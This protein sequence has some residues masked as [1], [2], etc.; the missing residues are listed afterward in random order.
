MT[1]DIGDSPKTYFTS[2]VAKMIGVAPTTVR[3]YSQS[4][5]SKGYS[6]LKGKGTGNRQ[7]RLFTDKDITVMRYLKEIRKDTNITVERATSIVIERF[8]KG[9]IQSTLS[10]H[11]AKTD[12][13]GQHDER[14]NE[15]KEIINKQSSLLVKQN[16][17]ILNL[18]D[19]LDQHEEYI[20]NKIAAPV[21]DKKIET[22]KE[23]PKKKG[24]L[25]RIFNK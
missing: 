12:D 13:L 24:L 16:E 1:N 3:K 7:A 25:A 21:E 14:Y 11:E 4:L 5:Q 17:L 20:N 9:T 23:A 6:F 22:S 18:S 2:D 19:R 8:G 10:N 15:L